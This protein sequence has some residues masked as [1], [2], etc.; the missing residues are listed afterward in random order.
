MA[1]S[2]ELI[3]KKEERINSL[4]LKEGFSSSN[5]FNLIK[6]QH[7]LVNDAV[8]KGRNY[9]V[10][11]GDN[12]FITLNDEIN[13]LYE[14]DSPIDIVFEDEYILIVNKPY[15]LDV[16]PSLHT[17]YNNLASMITYYFKVNSIKSKIHLVNRLDKLTSGLVIVAK[18]RYIKNRFSKVDIVKRYLCYVDGK[19]NEHEII[20]N[21]IEKD[22]LSDR[23]IVVNEGGKICKTEYRLLEYNDNKSLLEITLHTGRTHQIRATMKSINHPLT[24]D[25]LYN[26]VVNGDMFLKAYY[27]K[28]THPILGKEVEIRL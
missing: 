23:R 18:N 8:I 16:E 6:E 13:N 22:S 20:I 4:L 12:V 19:T 10:H 5:I 3:A 1:I 27:L 28:F 15:N 14:N 2:F 17:T 9:L 21:R 24:N 7:V 25:P 26:D 11:E